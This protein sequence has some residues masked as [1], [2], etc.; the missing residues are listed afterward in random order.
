MKVF[1]GI[2]QIKKK[3]KNP[4]IAIGVFDGLHRGHK[5]LIKRAVERAKA[6][7]GTP[8][9]I[10]FDPHPIQV[11]KAGVPFPMLV[12]VPFRIKL[13]ENMG[14]EVC[15][16]S[17]FTKRFASISPEEF[18]CKYLFKKFHPKEIFVGYD[19][20]FGKKR[21]GEL[22]IFHDLGNKYGFKVNVVKAVTCE[23][24][25][26]SST[27]IRNL[28]SEGKLSR[29]R[30]LLGHPVSIMETV[31]RGDARGA[32]L[33]FP[34]ANIT[35]TCEVIPP[36]GVYAVNVLVGK[37]KFMGM[38]NVGLRPSFNKTESHLNIEVH[39]FHFRK[40]LYGQQIIVEFIKRIRNERIFNS[41]KALIGQLKKDKEKSQSILQ[42]NS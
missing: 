38:A 9:V 37:K 40:E 23:R 5:Q 16:V 27:L 21:E 6:V 14:V 35:P 31:S 26:I 24:K 34:T 33:G 19:F 12:S 25:A 1:Y 30:R 28:I 11:L 36:R 29:A 10:T 18:V 4:V 2:N 13:I 41:S 39:I 3:F 20:R 7:S 42:N 8:I 22:D 32:T 17:N 15:L